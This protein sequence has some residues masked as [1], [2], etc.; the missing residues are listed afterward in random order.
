MMYIFS[1]VELLLKH[2]HYLKQQVKQA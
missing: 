1:D 2:L